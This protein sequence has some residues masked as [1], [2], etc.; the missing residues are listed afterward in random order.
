MRPMEQCEVSSNKMLII[1]HIG[2]TLLIHTPCGKRQEGHAKVETS[3]KRKKSMFYKH[4]LR[5]P[6]RELS[7]PH[8]ILRDKWWP[9]CRISCKFARKTW[10][11]RCYFQTGELMSN[12]RANS[13]KNVPHVG[14]CVPTDASHLGFVVPTTQKVKTHK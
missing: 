5:K 6:L 14:F 2:R 12:F 9:S 3:N 10:P 13:P 8:R 4:L 11:C 7:G 1:G